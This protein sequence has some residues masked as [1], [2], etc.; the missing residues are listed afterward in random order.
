MWY[1]RKGRNG[2]VEAAKRGYDET[3]LGIEAQDMTNEIQNSR[4]RPATKLRLS[5]PSQDPPKL[6]PC[7]CRDTVQGCLLPRKPAFLADFRQPQLAKVWTPGNTKKSKHGGFQFLMALNDSIY[8][9]FP[10]NTYLPIS[11]SRE[12][13]CAMLPWGLA[14]T[15]PVLRL[16]L[17]P[18]QQRYRL[19]DSYAVP[20]G[21][22][23]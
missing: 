1:D 9:F 7:W 13:P 6:A 17:W 11:I 21:N 19:E 8:S 12:W 3:K 16:F 4:P 10:I 23:T 15:S 18:R 14:P 2:P 5:P 20:S 22:S